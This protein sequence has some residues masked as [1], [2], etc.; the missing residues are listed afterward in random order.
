MAVDVNAE[1]KRRLPDGSLASWN[2]NTDGTDPVA[3]AE[4][5]ARLVE[6]LTRLREQLSVTGTVA[7]DA[8]TLAAL[9]QITVTVSNAETGLAKEATLAAVLTEL[10]QKL[11]PADLANLA[12]NATLVEVRDR[13]PV[14]GLATETTLEALRVLVNR[15]VAPTDY[16]KTE[17]FY[18]VEALEGRM[19]GVGA[20]MVTDVTT[21]NA[22]MTIT[23]P[24]GSGKRLIVV[25]W[26]C[27][28][29]ATA[30][31]L[32]YFDG[33]NTGTLRTPFSMS[34]HISPIPVSTS[35]ARAGSGVYTP[36]SV[37]PMNSRV[38]TESP[39]RASGMYISLAPGQSFTQRF[40]GPGATNNVWMNF[41]YAEKNL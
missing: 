39:L 30:T 1:L 27:Y 26:S 33:T 5:R 14:T 13:L 20:H 32:Y 7:L 16:L 40:L 6:I 18:E 11:E 12:T 38:G 10:S 35:E 17:N 28:A 9:E 19:F 36:G 15:V 8:P 24:V 4:V 25:S 22:E 3:D 2:L 31:V 37:L 29:D 21:P 41:E 34:R 23:N